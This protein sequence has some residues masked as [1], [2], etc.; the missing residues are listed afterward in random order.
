L[1]RRYTSKHDLAGLWSN[2]DFEFSQKINAQNRTGISCLQKTGSEHFALEPGSFGDERGDWFSICSL[3]KGTGWAAVRR[4]RN[5]AQCCSSVNQESVICQFV[6]EKNQAI[7]CREMH[8]GGCGM[9][10]HCRL[11]GKDSMAL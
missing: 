7:I 6:G 3:E 10:R 9:Y 8:G 11:A 4:T 1:G 5:N 2:S